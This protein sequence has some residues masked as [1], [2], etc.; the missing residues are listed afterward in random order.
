MSAMRWLWMVVVIVAGLGACGSPTVPAE[1]EL[2]IDG[3]SYD[4]LTASAEWDRVGQSGA[5]SAYLTRDDGQE[6]QPYLGIRH[7]SGNPVARLWLRHAGPGAAE[8]DDL[9][10]FECFVPGT[11]LDGRPTLGWQ[12]AGGGERNR[13]ETGQEGCQATI[14]EEGDTLV[15]TFDATMGPRREVKKKKGKEAEGEPAADDAPVVE[16]K[17][18][19]KA[20]LK[21]R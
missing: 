17:V 3:T 6:G 18:R 5:F 19:G 15:L 2:E 4:Y 12:Q 8:G 7:Y 11:L 20:T 9:Q 10:R 16:L 13:Q 14:V 1:V 21:L